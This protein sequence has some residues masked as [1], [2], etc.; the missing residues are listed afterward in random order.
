MC[1]AMRLRNA[2][3]RL[4]WPS[5]RSLPVN[6]ATALGGRYIHAHIR[7]YTHRGEGLPQGQEV[8]PMRR[9]Q[10]VKQRKEEKK[11]PDA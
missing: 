1:A 11:D 3:L 2:H 9:L 5:C 6:P 10:I 8:T 4:A 7:T